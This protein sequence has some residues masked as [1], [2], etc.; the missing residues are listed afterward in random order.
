MCRPARSFPTVICRIYR[1]LSILSTRKIRKFRR[2]RRIYRVTK[3]HRIHPNIMSELGRS[4]CRISRPIKRCKL[5][6]KRALQ[7]YQRA[8]NP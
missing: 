5:K 7:C 3:V 2:L 6:V 8:L 1:I 4:L